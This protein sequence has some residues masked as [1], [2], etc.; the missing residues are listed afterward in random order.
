MD[1]PS[2]KQTVSAD[3]C[4]PVKKELTLVKK[5]RAFVEQEALHEA[6]RLE[7]D[8]DERLTTEGDFY[9]GKKLD[10]AMHRCSFYECGGCLKPYFGGLI[11]CEEEMDLMDG[12]TKDDFLCKPC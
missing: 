5:L 8:K 4:P 11:D 7:I 6:H 1:C 2:C 12:K 10:Y 9:F 3:H